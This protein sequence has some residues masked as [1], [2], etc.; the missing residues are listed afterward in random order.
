MSWQSMNE[1]EILEVTESW[2]RDLQA[3]DVYFRHGIIMDTDWLKKR[4]LFAS[5]DLPTPSTLTISLMSPDK[6]QRFHFCASFDEIC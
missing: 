2:V 3:T 4:E 6:S 5:H 1:S